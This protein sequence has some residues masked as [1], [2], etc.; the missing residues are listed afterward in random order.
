MT[1]EQNNIAVKIISVANLLGKILLMSGAETYRVEKAISTVCR[2]FGLKSESFVTITC[3]VTSAKSSDGTT[4][5]EVNRIYNLSNNLDKIDKVNKI[6][7]NIEDYNLDYLEFELKRI[8]TESLYKE[9][10]IL[11]S[12]FFAAAFFSLLFKGRLIDFFIAGFGGIIVFYMTKIANKLKLNNFFINTLGGFLVTVLASFITKFNLTSSPS[13]ATI[14]TL[15]LL[16]PGLALT[17]AIRDLI[18]GDLIAGTSRTVE[19]FLV[20]SALAI[21]TGFGLFIF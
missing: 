14:G 11:I 18:N 15:M 13:Y 12:Y 19:A 16:V 2:R 21:G 4:I 10:L 20:G 7:L 9:K 3:I 17:N 6:I 5:S 1:K 8:Q